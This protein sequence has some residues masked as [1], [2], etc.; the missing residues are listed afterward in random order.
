MLG[1]SLVVQSI[2]HTPGEQGCWSSW[3]DK[4]W[5][6]HFSPQQAPGAAPSEVSAKLELF[7]WLGLG[8]QARACTSELPLDLLPEPS[9]GLPHSLHQDGEY[10][11]GPAITVPS[12]LF[13]QDVGLDAQLGVQ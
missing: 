3:G 6:L 12:S 7:L 11:V 9:V 5:A 10:G 2:G 8:K 1:Y 13:A 4:K